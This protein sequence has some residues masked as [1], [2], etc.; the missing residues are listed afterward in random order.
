MGLIEDLIN[1]WS[2]YLK[3]D[4]EEVLAIAKHRASICAECPLAT[5]G[6]HLS[7]LPD[8]SFGEIQGYYCDKKQGGCGCP[9][10]TAIRSK[11]KKCP[12]GKW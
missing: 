12:L 10:S 7:V 2:N 4:N 9:I 6:K 8:H 5:F 11:N 1:G 3:N